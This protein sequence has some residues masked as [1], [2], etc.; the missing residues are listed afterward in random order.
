MKQQ[1]Q[2]SGNCSSVRRVK[3]SDTILMHAKRGS[4]RRENGDEKKH[5][6][7]QQKQKEQQQK[8]K[9]LRETQGLWRRSTDCSSN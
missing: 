3:T 2:S 8:Q 7:Q 9:Q 6:Q 1:Q 5:P 4:M